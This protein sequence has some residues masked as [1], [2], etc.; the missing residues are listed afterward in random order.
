MMLGYARGD[1]LMAKTTPSL[2]LRTM[3]MSA[4]SEAEVPS[5][6]GGDSAGDQGEP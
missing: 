2:M 6:K 4:T 5:G 3:M 1:H